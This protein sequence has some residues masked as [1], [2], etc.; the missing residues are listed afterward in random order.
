MPSAPK[1]KSAPP[2]GAKKK[3]S[4][5]TKKAAPPLQPTP[6][7]RAA[8]Q[9]A[10]ER[11]A[12]ELTRAEQAA[13]RDA[14]AARRSLHDVPEESVPP[15]GDPDAGAAGPAPTYQERLEGLDD[16][17]H[18]WAPQRPFAT[19][20]RPIP[21]GQT[22][23]RSPVVPQPEQGNGNGHQDDANGNGNGRK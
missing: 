9:L 8:T 16:A 18:Q 6:T 2:T 13:A 5:S 22:L 4:K 10:L 12:L 19:P 20:P 21:L 23:Q 3:K 1:T 11:A 14:R 7:E 17:V 15:G